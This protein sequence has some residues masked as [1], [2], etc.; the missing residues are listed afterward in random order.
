L[1]ESLATAEKDLLDARED[2]KLTTEDKV[3]AE[4]VLERIKPGCDFITSN[5]KLREANRATEKNA[6][7]KAVRLIKRTP[8]YKTAVNEATVASYG[9]CKQP[10]TKDEAAV[11]CKACMA[12]VTIPA[13]CAGHKG[14]K[15]C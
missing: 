5:F 13:Y 7:Q 3:A 14:V 2:L 4:T 1:H 8:A 6:L 10:C 11:E 9:D 12:D 15:G